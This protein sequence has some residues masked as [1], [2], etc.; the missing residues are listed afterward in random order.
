ML[1]L[2]FPEQALRLAPQLLRLEQERE[3][4]EPTP[5]A[6]LKPLLQR[7]YLQHPLITLVVA[8][9][10]LRQQGLLALVVLVAV[11]KER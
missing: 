2:L 4:P 7:Q 1:A 10:V 3:G 6:H 11:E 5:S 8:A 9:A